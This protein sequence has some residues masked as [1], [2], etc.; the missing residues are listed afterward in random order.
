LKRVNA[1]TSHYNGL[2]NRLSI[3]VEITST[4]SPNDKL[5][6]KAI[7]DTGATIST[8]NNKLLQK[9]NLPQVA[10]TF[11]HTANG[12]APASIHYIDITMPNNVMF[13]QRKVMA[14][15]LVDTEMLIGMDIIA[16]C[17]FAVTN[18][19]K[20]TTVSF[21]T[22][23]ITEIDFVQQARDITPYIKGKKTGGNEMCPCGS[24][25]KYK[26]CCGKGK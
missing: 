11:S 9:I 7:W 10:N 14:M 20:K 12:T 19:N 2:T 25:K 15:D 22:P 13:L 17:D 21:R 4:I 16:H 8:I 1:H 5:K 23:S 18:S 3:E 26:N 6:V 24:G